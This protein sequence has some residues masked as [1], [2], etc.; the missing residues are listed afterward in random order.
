M[1]RLQRRTM[2]DKDD[3]DILRPADALDVVADVAEREVD[4]FNL[5]DVVD[6]FQFFGCECTGGRKERNGG[7]G[8]KKP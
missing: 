1:K 4:L 8:K 6:D 2:G 5:R 3:L 7:S